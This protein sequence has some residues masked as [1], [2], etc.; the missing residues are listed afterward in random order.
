MGNDGPEAIAVS[1]CSLGW[2]L[3][4]AGIAQSDHKS[5]TGSSATRS[6]VAPRGLRPSSFSPAHA[7]DQLVDAELWGWRHCHTEDD[8]PSSARVTVTFAS[9]GFTTEVRFEPPLVGEAFEGC[10]RDAYAV[11]EVPAFV[12]GPQAVSMEL[13]G[14]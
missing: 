9:D 4:F 3:V 5:K 11:C 13:G 2:Q 12:G 10:M 1:C 6:V 8:Q 14:I 7:A